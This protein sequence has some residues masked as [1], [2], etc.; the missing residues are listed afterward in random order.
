MAGPGRTLRLQD[1]APDPKPEASRIRKFSSDTLPEV[2]W[3][4]SFFLQ[5]RVYLTRDEQVEALSVV[6]IL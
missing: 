1:I 2:S 6:S 4:R 5:L 3:E